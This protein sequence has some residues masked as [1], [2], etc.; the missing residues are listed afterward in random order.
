MSARVLAAALCAAAG[1]RGDDGQG[2]FR[3]FQYT[4]RS[5]VL[6]GCSECAGEPDDVCEVRAGALSRPL[7]DYAERRWPARGR[8]K[9][10]RPSADPDCAVAQRGQVE[11]AAIR[12]SQAVPSDAALSLFA[13]AEATQGW[14][15]SPGRRGAAAPR[16][17][18]LDRAA[19]RLA[20]VCWP[21]EEG[22][23]A[24]EA[25]GADAPASLDARNECELWLL[26]L[27]PGGE[28]PDLAAPS[29]LLP[30]GAFPYGD[31][32]R[33]AAF[34]ARAPLEAALLVPEAAAPTPPPAPAPA[35][36][37]AAAARC[38]PPASSA[39]LD[40]FD[41]WERR[42]RGA[43]A[44]SLDRRAFALDGAAWSGHCLEL[45]VLRGVLERQVGCAL[46]LRTACASAAGAQRRGR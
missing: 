43:P 40:R 34:D 42:V 45:D 14:P 13:D 4:P 38:P 32:R 22:W 41:Q 1:A 46:Q 36:P 8:L 39:A 7:A 23:P 10:L 2:G 30:G 3:A 9:L 37:P 28:E 35:A 17:T 31:A 12:L 19:L 21:S 16:T 5:V 11:L 24:P 29:L 6:R 25:G 20:A 15:R 27:K 44:Q 18:H 26:P 33:A